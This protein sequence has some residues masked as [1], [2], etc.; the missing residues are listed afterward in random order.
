MLRFFLP[1]ALFCVSHLAAQHFCHTTEKQNEWLNLHPEYRTAFEQHRR[2]LAEL[3]QQQ[4]KNH[5]QRA[6]KTTA[7]GIYTVPVVF[8][9]LH[10]GTGEN[11]SDAQVMDA[12]QI[13]T[14]DFN[15]ANADTSNVVVPFKN[16]IGNAQFDFV[17]ATKD[18]NGNC[19]NGII[20]HFDPNTDWDG[21]YADYA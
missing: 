16:L 2:K 7:A 3:D 14:R 6:G 12:V 20:R 8:H 11:I 19:T 5:Y 1:F 15:S 10:T 9:I 4:Y 17:L 13:L 21:D 18:P